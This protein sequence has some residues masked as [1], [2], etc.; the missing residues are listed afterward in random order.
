VLINFFS[1]SPS[2][3]IVL[4]SISFA[5]F[6]KY[7][8]PRL[9]QEG[10]SSLFTVIF[11]CFL[12]YQEQ[13]F[14]NI[15]IQFNC[16]EICKNLLSHPNSQVKTWTFV[17]ISFIST[18]LKQHE[19]FLTLIKSS[20]NDD[21]PDVRISVLQSLHSFISY[22]S[23][24][25]LVQSTLLLK[26][27]LHSSIR[28]HLLLLFLNLFIFSSESNPF[29]QWIQSIQQT[30]VDLHDDPFSLISVLSQNVQ[31]S[32]NEKKGSFQ[33]PLF[34][35]YF[36]RFNSFH[37]SSKASKNIYFQLGYSSWFSDESSK[38]TLLQSGTSKP[39]KIL[40]LSRPS[41]FASNVC[42]TQND[43]IFVGLAD[44][45]I[46]SLHMFK[47][48]LPKTMSLS[49]EPI[50]SIL[51]IDNLILEY[52]CRPNI[53]VLDTE[54]DFKVRTAFSLI[55]L[56]NVPGAFKID[57]SSFNKQM[58]YYQSRKY[59]HLSLIDI[60]QQKQ[61][62]QI[63]IEFSFIQSAHFIQKL[64]KLISFCNKSFLLFDSRTESK[65]PI[66]Q[67]DFN[68]ELLDAL[69]IANSQ[70]EFCACSTNGDLVKIDWRIRNKYA[71]MKFLTN[72]PISDV[73]SF[74]SSLNYPIVCL[75]LKNRAF[76]YGTESG[77]I[78][79]YDPI[80]SSFFS[81]KEVKPIISTCFHPNK[82]NLAFIHNPSEIGI[83]S[84]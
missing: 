35:F 56:S 5:F 64:D 44:G 55:D 75:G 2:S 66:F 57:C 28:K 41:K 29:D 10:D 9:T 60:E 4:H 84:S 63:K 15:F 53:F 62:F 6:E 45:S 42:L 43:E 8:I 69:T 17:L 70:Y 39:T 40:S 37:L 68:H 19:N 65:K 48:S 79:C 73:L 30:I 31:K 49:K 81:P 25:G 83:L 47:K 54:N 32:I 71:P 50:T 24:H 22:S 36:D 59:N 72:E 12:L 51:T 78:H 38:S 77:I 20:L 80:S 11:L 16:Y 33:F 13:Y 58:M 21:S 26:F 46:H 27:D 1:V 67:S 74:D 52:D 14:I 34:D 61:L 76:I 18:K 82:L 23:P 3:R 7:L